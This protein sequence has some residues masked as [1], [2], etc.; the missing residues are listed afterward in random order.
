MVKT[1]TEVVSEPSDSTDGPEPL[2]GSPSEDFSCEPGTVLV[3]D[4]ASP[5]S[6]SSVVSSSSKDS[7]RISLHD[8]QAEGR[9]QLRSRLTHPDWKRPLRFR[10]FTNP[11][12]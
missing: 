5:P 2:P 6:V 8:K 7:S 3:S 9:E 1:L 10:L 4:N 11:Q 12:V